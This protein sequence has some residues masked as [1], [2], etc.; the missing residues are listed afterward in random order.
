ML[1]L[2]REFLRNEDGFFSI[3]GGLLGKM[4]GSALTMGA[5]GAVG[6]GAGIGGMIGSALGS[7]LDKKQSMRDDLSF[8]TRDYK[9]MRALGFTH[10][11]I[12][13]AGDA[14]AS[15]T[16]QAIM[17]NQANQMAALKEQQ[18]FDAEQRAL[19]RQLA[20]TQTAMQTGASIEAAGIS[21]GPGYM[22]ARTAA[23]IAQET[24][25]EI[26]ARTGKIDDETMRAN[27]ASLEFLIRQAQTEMDVKGGITPESKR[28]L[29]A[30]FIARGVQ[31]A[32]ATADDV[33][34]RIIGSK[35]KVQ[36]PNLGKG[37]GGPSPS[38]IEP[39]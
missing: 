5:G 38:L 17:G 14:G 20:I 13:G 39:F 10:S 27:L 26:Q 28:Q 9:R 29:T 21:A 1:R 36:T 31:G 11:E 32:A 7:R 34:K 25:A 2:V 8:A 24:I 6:A 15:N 30:Y 18:K 4:A 3:I 19:D 22:Q 12:A 16:Q 35:V 37:K 33:I 23:A